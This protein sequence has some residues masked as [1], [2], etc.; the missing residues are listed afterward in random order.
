MIA[1][2][3]AGHAVAHFDDN[4]R[5]LVAQ[6]GRENPFGVVARTGEFIGVT[7][8]GGLD[9]NQNLARLPGRQG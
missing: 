7:Q 8:A 2:F 3:E 5:A 4:A 9:L 6:D 1:D